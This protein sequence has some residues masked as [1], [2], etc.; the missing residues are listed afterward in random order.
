[1]TAGAASGVN[2]RERKYT[3]NKKEPPPGEGRR[4]ERVLEKTI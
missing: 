4:F 2:H 1:M 3:P